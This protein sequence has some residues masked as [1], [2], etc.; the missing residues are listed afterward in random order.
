MPGQPV[1]PNTWAWDCTNLI[2]EDNMGQQSNLIIESGHSF[3]LKATID[4]QVH[5]WDLLLSLPPGIDIAEVEFFYESMGPGPDGTFGTVSIKSDG[6]IHPLPHSLTTNPLV[7]TLNTPATYKL[8]AVVRPKI[9]LLA[10][11]SAFYE[12]PIIQQL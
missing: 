2:V 8:V 11:C 3:Q 10:R 9:S 6:G 1:V 4:F 5:W 7:C 12:G